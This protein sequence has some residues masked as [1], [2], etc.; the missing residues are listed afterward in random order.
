[1]P[2]MGESG[3][4]LTRVLHQAGIARSSVSLSNVFSWRPK[5]NDLDHFSLSRFEWS[6]KCQRNLWSEWRAPL[7]R[8]WPEALFRPGDLC[9]GDRAFEEGNPLSWP[10]D[11]CRPWKYCPLGPLSD[12]R[13]WEAARNRDRVNAHP[14]P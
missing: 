2:F 8:G 13:H 6:R 5:N 9:S 14:R 10:C 7:S 4:E 11:S 12:Y 1:M 3:Q